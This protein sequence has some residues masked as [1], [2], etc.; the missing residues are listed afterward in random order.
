MIF[1][2][3]K[4]SGIRGSSEFLKKQERLMVKV[5]YGIGCRL[6]AS[7]SRIPFTICM[8][9]SPAEYLLLFAVVSGIG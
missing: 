7:S 3:H 4:L 9:S 5:I 2:R 6:S 1:F 8:R